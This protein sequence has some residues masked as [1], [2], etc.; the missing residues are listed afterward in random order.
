ML[1]EK[2]EGLLVFI[3][4]HYYKRGAG[5]DLYNRVSGRNLK[6]VAVGAESSM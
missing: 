1:S 6:V 4:L 5:I 3:D 2:V